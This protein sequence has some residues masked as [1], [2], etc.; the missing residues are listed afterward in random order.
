MHLPTRSRGS[1]PSH[2]PRC[3]ILGFT[4]TPEARP[5]LEPGLGLPDLHPL[6]SQGPGS[7][8]DSR[9]RS[10]GLDPGLD[11]GSDRD[12]GGTMRSTVLG[13]VL[14]CIRVRFKCRTDALCSAKPWPLGRNS[15]FAALQ[16]YRQ[17]CRGTYSVPVGLPAYPLLTPFK[18]QVALYLAGL[19]SADRAL[20]KNGASNQ[21]SVRHPFEARGTRGAASDSSWGRLRP[22]L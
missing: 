11:S 4:A 20:K 8:R 16:R 19:V 6:S 17:S 10:A 3:R 15:P 7:E 14:N 1:D 2:C 22:S 12:D 13:R 21:G 5:R 18:S 9:N